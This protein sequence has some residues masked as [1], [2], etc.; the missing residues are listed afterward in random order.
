M[1]THGPEMAIAEYREAIA[2]DPEYPEAHLNLGLTLADQGN[3]E[4]ARRALERA[5]ELDP[6]DPYPRHELAAMLMDEGDHRTAIGL[7]KEV[8]RLEPANFDAW[9]DLGICFAQ[10]GF[11]A[12]AD[13][14]YTRA[15]ELQPDDLLLNYNV[16]ALHALWGRPAAALEA[17][18]KA[19]ALDPAKVRSWLDADP[20]FDALK[21]T[22]DFEALAHG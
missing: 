14:A 4:E 11:Y 19:L 18:R 1:A 8:A 15:R 3:T 9:L 12:E 5:I 6:K 7:L 17:L 13:R 10:K 22:P 2:L 20:M 16:A 21:G